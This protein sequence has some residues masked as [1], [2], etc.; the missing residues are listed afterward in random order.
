MKTLTKG[1]RRIVTIR[2]RG[3]ELPE[4]QWVV[5]LDSNGL[6]FRRVGSKD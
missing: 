1:I 2:G 5:W 4:R 3:E 6:A